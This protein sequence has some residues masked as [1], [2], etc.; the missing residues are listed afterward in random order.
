MTKEQYA[1]LD[2]TQRLMYDEMYAVAKRLAERQEEI[3]ELLK[4]I[5]AEAHCD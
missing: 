1:S 4:T 5:I 3:V 2:D